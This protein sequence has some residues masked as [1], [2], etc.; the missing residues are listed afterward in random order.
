[1]DGG[2][3]LWSWLEEKRL[4]KKPALRLAAVFGLCDETNTGTAAVPALKPAQPGDGG[5]QVQAEPECFSHPPPEPASPTHSLWE[6]IFLCWAFGPAPPCWC[7]CP[8]CQIA[9]LGLDNLTPSRI[10]HQRSHRHPVDPAQPSYTLQQYCFAGEDS[11][12]NQP[13]GQS[14]LH[15]LHSLRGWPAGRR[16]ALHREP[17]GTLAWRGRGARPLWACTKG[18]TVFLLSLNLG[19]WI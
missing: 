10:S 18:Y 15:C 6:E 16:L 1:M 3:P 9:H 11:P 8:W 19:H 2:W 12:R 7:A 17:V 4:E 13:S 5:R 14:L